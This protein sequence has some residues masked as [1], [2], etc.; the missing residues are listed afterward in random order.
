MEA[1]QCE[2]AS[3]R[4]AISSFTAQLAAVDT[5]LQVCMGAVEVMTE[6]QGAAGSQLQSVHMAMREQ[7]THMIELAVECDRRH[8]TAM[9]MQQTAATEMALIGKQVSYGASIH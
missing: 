4:E 1:L 8:E 7:Q 2:Q 5:N 3:Q 6:Q 9:K